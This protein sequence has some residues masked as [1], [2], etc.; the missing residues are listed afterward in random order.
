MFLDARLRKEWRDTNQ[1]EGI[2]DAL[3]ITLPLDSAR[4][5]S[6]E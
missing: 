2:D 4:F 3:K 5:T 6:S 1:P